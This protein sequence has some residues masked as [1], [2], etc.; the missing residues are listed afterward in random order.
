M[1][2]TGKNMFAIE[3]R[4]TMGFWKNLFSKNHI[5]K[6]KPN[7][8]FSCSANEIRK[9]TSDLL[10]LIDTLDI[11]DKDAYEKF[12][13]ITGREDTK[14]SSARKIADNIVANVLSDSRQFIKLVPEAKELAVQISR[15]DSIDSLSGGIKAEH[16]RVEYVRKYSSGPSDMARGFWVIRTGIKVY[17]KS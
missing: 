6:E 16:L 13:K 17:V 3:R 1:V 8:I 15:H 9:K 10:M 11:S 2:V 7:R 12:K 14:F 4:F 5:T